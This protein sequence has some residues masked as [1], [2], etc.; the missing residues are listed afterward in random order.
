MSHYQDI[1]GAISPSIASASKIAGVVA[2][3][4]PPPSDGSTAAVVAQPKTSTAKQIFGIL[5][6]AA[7]AAAGAYYWK[8]HRVLG[9]MAGGAIANSAAQYYKGEKK[10][11]LYGLAIEA[12]AIT[13]A[14]RYKSPV[15]G[16]IGGLVAATAVAACIPGSPQ[17]AMLSKIWSEF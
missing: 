13:G 7:G 1:L 15:A 16:Y 8:E 9:I 14:L 2:A 3:L 4:S 6:I 17:R 11:A 5:P 12:A 10:N